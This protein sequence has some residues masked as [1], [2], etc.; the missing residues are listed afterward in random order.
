VSAEA[1]VRGRL[2]EAEFLALLALSVALAALGIDIMLPAFGA[3]RSELGLPADSTAVGGLVTAYFVGLAVGQLGHGPLS[4]RFGR[5]RVLY[6]GYAMYGAGAVLAAL[7]PSLSLLLLARVVWGLGAAGP[8]VVTVAVIRDVYAGERMSRA[9][10]FVM[11]VFLLVPILAP[12]VGALVVAV[13]SWR[14]VFGVCVIAAAGMALW[15]IRLPETLPA[16]RRLEL[17]AGRLLEATRFVLAD[18]RTVG[19]SIGLTALFGAFLSY[20]AT[21]E[22]VIGDV[23]GRPTVFPAVFGGLALVMGA[24][25]LL[26][27]RVV[28][29]IGTRRLAHRVLRGYL[30]V[31]AGLVVTTLAAGGPPPFPVFLVGMAML[32]GAHALLIP[33]LTSLAM[34]PMGT[35]AG[36]ASSLVGAAQIAGGAA[37][38][39]ALDRLYDGT[40][41]PL[42]AGFLGLGTVALLAVLV[43]ER[44]PLP[45]TSDAVDVAPLLPP[46]PE[47]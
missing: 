33:N 43:A 4:D 47:A 37:L 8:R 7:A 2:G 24:A 9:M 3:I 27:A 20:I 35:V 31:A 25:V 1:A 10:S 13:A 30:V 11:A 21:S 36:T 16:D 32:L 46:T 5:R 19:Y 44:G 41:L 29:R 28:G 18:R 38:G 17:R 42:S 14:W 23:Y 34:A 12:T 15:A 39:A 40:T 22:L 45:S 6:A 26:N